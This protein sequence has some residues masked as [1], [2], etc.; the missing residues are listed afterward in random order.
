MGLKQIKAELTS[1]WGTDRDSANAAWASSVDVE[2]LLTRSDEDVRRVVSGLVT[3]GHD[4]P[5]ERVWCEF[6]VTCP[7]FVERQFDKYRLT[8]QIQDIQIGSNLAEFGRHGITQ[9]ELSGRY[10]T[11]PNRP[12]E[13]PN[14]VNHILEQATGLRGDFFSVYKKKQEEV[15]FYYNERLKYLRMARDR[16]DISNDAYKRARDVLR[17]LLPLATLTDMRI[18][19]NMNAFEWMG[20]QRLPDNAQLEAR[21]LF[22]QMLMAVRNNNVAPILVDKMVEVNKWEPYLLDIAAKIAEDE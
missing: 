21:V 7:I 15:F 17:G 4:T 19:L 2:K 10:R 3:Q 5:K 16:G 1:H 12:Y 22:Y 8:T 6:F 14:D 11:L 13:M 20:N 9:N 18:V